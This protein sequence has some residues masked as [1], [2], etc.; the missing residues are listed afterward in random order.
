[1]YPSARRRPTSL[2]IIIPAFN[3]VAGIEATLTRVQHALAN[4]KYP[5]EV[6]VVDD[7]SRDGTGEAAARQGARVISHAANR[8]YGAALKTGIL[9]TEAPLVAIMDAD[10]SY[11]ADALPRLSA[12]L[13]T[14]DMVVGH[15]VRS[16]DV[17]WIR[18]AGKWVLNRFAGLLMG[19]RV[20]DLNSGQRVIKRDVLLRYL[21]LM[22]DGFSFTSTITLALLANGHAVTY[23]PIHYV[24]R[25]GHPK[26]R[27]AHFLGFLLLVVRGTVLFNPLRLFVPLGTLLFLVGIARIVQDAFA[28]RLSQAS[29]MALLSAVIVWALGLLADMISRLQLQPPWRT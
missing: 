18:R 6:I 5:S 4:L 23:E 26:V 2:A 10:G 7:G 29:A 20:P 1:M 28:W 25:A 27:L 16:R 17:P 11:D 8:G 13:A 3:E 22:P 19:R 14:A 21:H 9:A 12:K 24:Q 15:R